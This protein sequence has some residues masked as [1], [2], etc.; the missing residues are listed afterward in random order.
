MKAVFVAHTATPSGAELATLRLA[1]ALRAHLDTAV[2]YTADGPMVERTHARG[3]ETRVLRND[4]DSRAMT[5]RTA[6]ARRLLTGATALLRVGWALGATARELEASVLVA[7]STKALLMGAV[8]ARRA[9][10]PLV[11]QVHDRIAPDYFGRRLAPLLRLLGL[12]VADAYLANS[13]TTL[14]SLRTG[15]KPAAVAYPGLE[16]R[17][18]GGPPPARVAP[19][20]TSS[21]ATSPPERAGEELLPAN[22]IRPRPPEETVVAVVGRLAPWKGQDLFLR[23][24]AAT[25]VRPARILLIGGAFFGEEPYR[26]ELERLAATSG[27]PVTF[28]GHVEDPESLLA[29]VDILVHCSVLPEPFG[30]VV[31]EGMRSGC[32]VIATRPGGPAEIVEPETNGLLV[33]ARDATE[34][35]AALDRLIENPDLRAKLADAARI[36][37]RHF[38]ITETARVVAALLASVRPPGGRRD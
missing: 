30:Q 24:V 35:T 16:P 28:A 38:D 26:A 8:A 2:V 25:R 27:L 21:S 4:F 14:A 18:D 19:A 37:A 31:V 9:R 29:Q 7:E 34:L 15:R 6:S 5:I 17:P 1:A 23:A 3:I 20:G 12:L 10:I 36:R 32:A 11:W 13:R 22:G 33:T